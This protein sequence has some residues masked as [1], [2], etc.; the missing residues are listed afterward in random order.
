MLD[1]K[2]QGYNPQNIVRE[3][4][5]KQGGAQQKLAIATAH[6][7]SNK[8]A[9]ADRREKINTIQQGSSG[10]LGCLGRGVSCSSRSWR[11]L[12]RQMQRAGC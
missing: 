12:G 1:Y 5:N 3:R 11:S 6:G 2:S 4:Q 7:T 8:G 10:A 9:S